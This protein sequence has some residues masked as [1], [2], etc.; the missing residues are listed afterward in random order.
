MLEIWI[1]ITH[2][3][4]Q[5]TIATTPQFEITKKAFYGLSQRQDNTHNRHRL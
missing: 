4:T 1:K 2:N 3:I 5:Q